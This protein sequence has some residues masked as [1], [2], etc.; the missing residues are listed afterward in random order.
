MVI[1]GTAVKLLEVPAA[2][3]LGVMRWVTKIVKEMIT[4]PSLPGTLQRALRSLLIIPGTLPA[5]A[6]ALVL[7]ATPTSGQR[8]VVEVRHAAGDSAVAG[9]MVSLIGAAGGTLNQMITA[10]DGRAVFDLE[11]AGRYAV[12]ASGLGWTTVRSR[13]ISVSRRDRVVVSIALQ[14]A[15]VG[16][17]P[18]EVKVSRGP[19]WR[20]E[21]PWWE[22]PFRERQEWYGRLGAGRFYT[23]RE[24]RAYVRVRDLIADRAARPAMGGLRGCR[25]WGDGWAYY[26][27][28]APV[29][30]DVLDL[31]HP[32]DLFGVEIY[33]G[34][35]NLP[36]ELAGIGRP[37][38]VISAWTKRSD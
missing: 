31:I 6:L 21:H 37:C 4:E 13:E 36:S 34:T 38:G 23:E 7:S 25:P 20:T 32:W 11:S 29:R 10:I 5:I 26:L 19:A 3:L 14:P 8:I 28:G 22:W 27:D 18:V 2:Y 35:A 17:V 24:L 15:P 12:T 33:A 9:A 16:L 1:C 30:V